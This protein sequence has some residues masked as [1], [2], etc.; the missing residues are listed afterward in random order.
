MNNKKSLIK[1]SP[2][3]NHLVNI[4][5]SIDEKI[6]NN[7]DLINKY[8]Y[9]MGCNLLANSKMDTV[10]LKEMC[11]IITKGTTPTTLGK[12]FVSTGINF[13]KAESILENHIIDDNKISFIDDDTHELLKRSVS[14]PAD[15]SKK[16]DKYAK[17]IELDN[18]KAITIENLKPIE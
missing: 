15:M 13:I 18:E 6:E 17:S 2:G 7:S 4:L 12:K 10:Q 16:L 14:V 9:L 11:S 8:N 5:G 1:L 3:N